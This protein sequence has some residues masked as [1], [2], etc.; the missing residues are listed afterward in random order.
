MGRKGITCDDV[1]RAYVALL[2]QGRTPGPRNL[3]LELG[4]GSFT[5]ISQHM[6]RLA[7]R[8]IDI[9][10][11]KLT[12]ANDTVRAAPAEHAMPPSFEETEEKRA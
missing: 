1:I 5:T 9:Q 4:R 10:T 8:Q 2:K 11:R 12:R 3:R 7:L 6:R